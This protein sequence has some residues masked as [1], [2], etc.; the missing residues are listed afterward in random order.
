[1]LPRRISP[2][3]FWLL[4]ATLSLLLFASSAPSPLYLQPPTRPKLGALVGVV[5]PLSGLAAGALATGLLVQY[6][7]DPTRLVFWLLLGGFAF[8]ALVAVAAVPETVHRDG[9][10]LH[11][12]RP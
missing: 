6:G 4:A 7:P 9:S 2:H 8:A 12:L 3:A 10:W 1:M 11:V 5:A